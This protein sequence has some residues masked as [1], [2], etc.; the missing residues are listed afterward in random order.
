MFRI[1]RSNTQTI[2]IDRAA[3]NILK[4]L[5]KEVETIFE[6]KETILTKDRLPETSTIF[7]GSTQSLSDLLKTARSLC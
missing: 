3:D 4:I 7:T 2:E 1:S 6:S 5:G